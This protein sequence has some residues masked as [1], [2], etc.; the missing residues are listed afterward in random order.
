MRDETEGWLKLLCHYQYF[1]FKRHLFTVLSDFNHGRF[2]F[3]HHSASPA[4]WA[5]FNV[6]LLELLIA[7][8]G[9]F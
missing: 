5:L 3:C 2:F 9:K 7:E 8:A 6:L 4:G 1:L